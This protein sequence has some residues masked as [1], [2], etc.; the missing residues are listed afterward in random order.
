MQLAVG[1][2]YVGTM[3]RQSLLALGTELRDS[4]G[5]AGGLR[6]GQFPAERVR[7]SEDARPLGV[8]RGGLHLGTGVAVGNESLAA[9]GVRQA[10]TVM[11]VE[12]SGLATSVC[13]A[14]MIV[15]PEP[16]RRK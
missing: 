9:L 10:R 6:G 14:P 4:L 7:V 3:S 8:D 13:I 12:L 2:L 15:L 11:T 16:D 1:R 5:V